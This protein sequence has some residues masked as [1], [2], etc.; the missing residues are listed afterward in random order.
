MPSDCIAEVLISSTTCKVD[1]PNNVFFAPAD[2][3]RTRT[4]ADDGRICSCLDNAL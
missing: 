3:G 2:M 1:S 4:A